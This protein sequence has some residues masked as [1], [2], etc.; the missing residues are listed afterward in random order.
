VGCSHIRKLERSQ[1]NALIISLKL[2]ENQKQANSQSGSQKEVLKTMAEVNE[3]ETKRTV[4]IEKADS[5]KK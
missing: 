1:I 3:L 2:L 5:L 4:T